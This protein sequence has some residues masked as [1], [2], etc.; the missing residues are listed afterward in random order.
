M[1]RCSL[2]EIDFM[3][4]S[5][6]GIG[7]AAGLQ[8]IVVIAV[9]L[10]GAP[11]LHAAAVGGPAV[12]RCEELARQNAAGRTITSAWSVSATEAFAPEASMGAVARN[13]CRVE[14]YIDDEIGFE[15][16][17]PEPG[18]WN[19]RILT[20]GVGGQAGAL[21]MPTLVRG[22]RRG[23]ATASTDAGHKVA[24]THWLLGGGQ[25]AV[26]YAERANHLLAV[27]VKQLV[28]LYYGAEPQHAYFIGCSGGGRQALTEVERY[29]ED[30]DGV[31]AGAPGVNTPE[32]SARRM[33]EMLQHAQ[34]GTLMSR[35][36]WDLVAD[37]ALRACDR[38]DGLADGQVEDPRRCNFEPHSLLCRGAPSDACLSAA[39][40]A[41]VR[42]VFA[43]LHDENGRRID[44]GLVYGVHVSAD[45]LP[46]PFTPG[47]RYLATVL[48][49]DGVHR[50]PEWDARQ[51][52]LARDL[53]AI[54]SVMNLHADSPDIDA[55]RA[56]GGKLLLYQGWM[57][58]LVSARS[59]LVWHAALEHR[60][61]RKALPSFAQLFM[62]PGMEHCRGGGVPDQF[63][64][65]GDDAPVVDAQH[66][67]LSA[68]E[69]WVAGGKAPERVFA[70]RIE[71]GRVT[72]TRPLCAWP[73]QAR[74]RGR[75]RSDDAANFACSIR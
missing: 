22:V 18:A 45:P 65:V 19:G 60:Y 9:M 34:F 62:V 75:G 21:N 41:A 24:D 49:G 31:I 50:D 66:D 68:L 69:T 63:G 30:Y 55:F 73:A 12:S 16:W 32:M 37:A 26:N 6:T 58:P 54:D 14:G 64:G 61:G 72:R 56:R 51:F 11:A 15:L 33:W 43:P 35:R 5:R 48:F 46:E 59:T 29:P 36:Q 25:R 42:R 38:L 47:P 57:D 52:S 10:A 23:Y 44:T 39:Q 4:Y 28:A 1:A 53:P 13:F 17:L 8:W 3:S 20:G 2:Q 74:Y 40:L 27:H 71:Q 67:L 70:A 7:G